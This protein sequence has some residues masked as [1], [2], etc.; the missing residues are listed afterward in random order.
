[1]RNCQCMQGMLIIWLWF[2]VCYIIQICCYTSALPLEL[3]SRKNQ[4]L[5]LSVHNWIHISLCKAYLKLLLVLRFCKTNVCLF[6]L[7][8]SDSELMVLIVRWMKCWERH[9]LC[10]MCSHYV[11]SLDA[12]HSIALRRFP[13]DSYSIQTGIVINYD[14]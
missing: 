14:M 6:I 9:L 3:Y 4:S 2:S 12:H 13:D 7:T 11:N 1:M 8:L 10:I 5:F